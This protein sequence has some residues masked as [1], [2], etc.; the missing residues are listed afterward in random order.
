M[1]NNIFSLMWGGF[2]ILLLA[3]F[4]TLSLSGEAKPQELE[5]C[6]TPEQVFA[7][8]SKPTEVVLH[9]EEGT[10]GYNFFREYVLYQYDTELVASD[11]IVY[12]TLNPD[13]LEVNVVGVYQEGCFVR[14]NHTTS[15]DI[16]FLNKAFDLGLIDL[17]SN[18]LKEVL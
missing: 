2:V 13:D 17:E 1:G 3:L 9:L 18:I 15:E 4:V 8:Q 14:V 6:Y 11:I 5:S 7:M 16:R 10:T 12:K